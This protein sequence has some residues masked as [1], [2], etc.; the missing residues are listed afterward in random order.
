MAASGNLQTLPT[1]KFNA[2]APRKLDVWPVIDYKFQQSA[3][4][5][6]DLLNMAQIDSVG[7][8]GTEE[9][10][11]IEAVEHAR[12]CAVNQNSLPGHHEQLSIRS[13]GFQLYQV[14]DAHKVVAVAV[15]E[16]H[17]VMRLERLDGIGSMLMH[18]G[19]GFQQAIL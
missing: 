8:A 5:V 1:P 6:G 4:E 19:E 7:T 16:Q 11:W 3:R 12:K 13:A 15:A 2:L 18:T 14:A 9:I 17:L 10:A